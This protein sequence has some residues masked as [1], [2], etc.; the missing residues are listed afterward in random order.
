[1][2]ILEGN[3]DRVTISA[4]VQTSLAAETGPGK[5]PTY[6]ANYRQQK[7][8]HRSLFS[9]MGDAKTKQTWKVGVR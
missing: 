6:S 3:V 7:E 5:V 4:R 9:T 1:M 2:Q 8:M